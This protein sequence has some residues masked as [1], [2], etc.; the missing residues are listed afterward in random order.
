MPKYKYVARDRFGKK[1][2]GSIFATDENELVDKL[3]A[4]NQVLISYE[5]K[6]AHTKKDVK[7]KAKKI[8]AF[9]FNLAA[10]LKGGLSLL[11]SLSSL[12]ED[13]AADEEMHS[14]INSIKEYIEAGGSLQEALE[15][16]PRTFSFLYRAIVS[17]G[18]KTGELTEVLE[19][20]ANYLEWEQDLK[21]KI[22]ELAAYPIIIFVVMIIVVCILVGFVLPKFIPIFEEAGADLPLMTKMVMGV[23][24]AF[25]KFWYL[26]IGAIILLVFLVKLL[27]KNPGVRLKFDALKIN[28]PVVGQLIFKI[29]LSRFSR[30]MALC[31]GGGIPAV[32]CLALGENLIGNAYLGLVVSETKRVVVSGGTLSMGFGY[33]NIFPPL[34]LRLVEVGERSGNLSEGFKRLCE[35]YDKEVPRTIRKIFTILEPLLIVIMGVVVGGIALAVFLPLIKMMQMVGG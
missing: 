34:L 21:A 18:E 3:N 4:I 15:L 27:L 1:V 9:T 35:F 30:S 22:T 8:L 16:H 20:V 25:R 28:L 14:M 23:S 31:L 24:Y 10:L 17:S 32:E 5:H 26:V 33:K 29:C 19:E 7:I 2:D 11:G 12:A 13:N 6:T